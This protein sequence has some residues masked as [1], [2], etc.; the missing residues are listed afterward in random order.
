MADQYKLSITEKSLRRT[1][2][3]LFFGTITT[4]RRID[5]RTS[6]KLIDQMNQHRT[7][8]ENFFP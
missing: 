6:A 1:I 2:R 3:R 4:P 8:R 5:E 7:E